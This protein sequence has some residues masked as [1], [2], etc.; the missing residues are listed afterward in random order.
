MMLKIDRQDRAEDCPDGKTGPGVRK[1]ASNSAV[2]FFA[3]T[4]ALA[5]QLPAVRFT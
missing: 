3:G 4:S 5:L 2:R 1:A